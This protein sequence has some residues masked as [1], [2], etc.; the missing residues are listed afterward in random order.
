MI[1]RP[2]NARF[3][4]AV[5]AGRKFTT[6]RDKP[7]TVGVP[8]MLYKWS[9][10]AYRS[11][12]NDVALVMVSGW[13]PITIA[14]TEAGEMRYAYGMDCGRAIHETE[15][16]DSRGEMDE[17]FRPLINPGQTATKHLMRFKLLNAKGEAR[18]DN[19][20]PPHEKTL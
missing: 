2:I 14:H 5:L 16:F 8:I 1:R 13:C 9:G 7:W 12:Q 17:W 3:S 15:G 10:A 11:P 6:I 19:A 20:T 18:A 4:A